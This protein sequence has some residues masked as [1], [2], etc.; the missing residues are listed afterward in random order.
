M[1]TISWIFAVVVVS[2]S[3]VPLFNLPLR[4]LRPDP[5]PA[6]SALNPETST[7]QARETLSAVQPENT[8]FSSGMVEGLASYCCKS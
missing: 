6:D 4:Y 7:K 5:S 8:L 3:S 2:E 1:K